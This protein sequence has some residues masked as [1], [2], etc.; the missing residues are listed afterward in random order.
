MIETAERPHLTKNE[1]KIGGRIKER[2]EDFEVEEI[3]AYEPC[4]EGHHCFLWLE[5]RDVDARSLIEIVAGHFGV[6][7]A[8]IGTAGS[9][10]RRAITRQWVSIP[11][12]AVEDGDAPATGTIAD[13]VE[14]L[15]QVNHKNKLRTGHLR[16]NRFRLRIRGTDLRG[17]ALQ[18]AVDAVGTAIEGDGLPN[19][20]GSQ[21]FG[22]GGSTLRAG[23][24]WLTK[25]RAPG[26]RFLRRM[27]ASALQS[28]I[29][30]RVLARRLT[31]KTWRTVMDGD[32][33]EKVDTGGRFWIDESERQETQRR[34]DDGAISV[35]GPMPGS[36]DGLAKGEAGAMEREVIAELGIDE[37]AFGVFGRRARGTR[38]ALT[39]F[40][41]HFQ[42]RVD[43]GDEVCLEF[44]LPSGSYATVLLR[45]FTG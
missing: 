9:K 15:R 27:A 16:G 18:R 22:D 41:R 40:P 19:Y 2:V 8:D 5:K 29:F 26:G 13:G 30:N 36:R 1:A 3:P 44:E 42:W 10:D 17:N 14:V 32:I 31:D 11:A 21:R 37:Q 4:G 25:G 35:T 43:D 33:F 38:R 20:Y 24:K 45:E 12:A 28:E 34:L 6:S 23:W 7:K 39:V